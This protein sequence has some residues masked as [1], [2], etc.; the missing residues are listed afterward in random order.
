MCKYI[1]LVFEESPKVHALS[2]L[3]YSYKKLA[4]SGETEFVS[5]LSLKRNPNIISQE[6]QNVNQL[7]DKNEENVVLQKT[8][9]KDRE[10]SCPGVNTT[11]E[12]IDKMYLDIL[13]KKISIGPPL[14]PQDGKINKV[15]IYIRS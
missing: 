10:N 6:P 1:K 9:N 12:H 3:F 15:S 11:E 8:T 5:P 2:V 4:D 13:R 7:F 14:L